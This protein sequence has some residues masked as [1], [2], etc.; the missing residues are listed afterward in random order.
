MPVYEFRCTRCEHKYEELV[1]RIGGKAPCPKCGSEEVAK[2][3]SVFSARMKSDSGS[4]KSVT[5]SSGCAGCSSSSCSGCS[6]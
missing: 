3:M 6:K 5:P 2:L 1:L 4:Y